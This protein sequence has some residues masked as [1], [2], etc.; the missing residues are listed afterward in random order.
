MNTAWSIKRAMQSNKGITSEAR[1][2]QN[3]STRKRDPGS[4][5]VVKEDE[6]WC[7]ST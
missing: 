3:Q 2:K 4:R 1:D 7:H 5:H 6:A